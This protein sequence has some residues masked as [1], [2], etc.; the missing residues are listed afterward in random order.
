MAQVVDA[1][2]PCPPLAGPAESL[3]DPAERLF[4]GGRCELGAALGAEEPSGGVAAAVAL[5]GVAAERRGRG[6]VERHE[7]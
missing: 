7:A 1:R 3:P 6:R 2:A 5:G 4:D